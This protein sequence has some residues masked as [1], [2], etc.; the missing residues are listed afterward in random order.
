MAGYGQKELADLVGIDRVTLTR[1]E[2]GDVSEE[3]MKTDL[4]IKIAVQCGF[5]KTFCCNRYHTFIANDSGQQIKQY[6]KQKRLTQVQL[7]EQLQ[8]SKTAVKRWEKNINK[9]S[10]N[11][12]ATMFPQLVVS[13]V[14]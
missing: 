4:L 11:K 3:N 10:P 7:A 14:G 6:R 2:N 5:D 1:L 12:V 9:P 13:D 8:V